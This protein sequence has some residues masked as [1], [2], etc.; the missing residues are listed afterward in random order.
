MVRGR[1]DRLEGKAT[2]ERQEKDRVKS[3]FLEPLFTSCR[4]KTDETY[5]RER[6]GLGSHATRGGH[7]SL[8]FTIHLKQT[9]VSRTAKTK[10]ALRRS[11]EFLHSA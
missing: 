1:H 2:E 4:I 11:H 5:L 6:R 10:T 7:S 8:S 3:V 9:W